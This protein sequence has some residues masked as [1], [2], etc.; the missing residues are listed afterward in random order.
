MY[1]DYKDNLCINYYYYHYHRIP[2]KDTMYIIN[3]GLYLQHET[4]SFYFH[5][6]PLFVRKITLSLARVI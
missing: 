6:I 2:D 5:S 3:K 4:S 1:L